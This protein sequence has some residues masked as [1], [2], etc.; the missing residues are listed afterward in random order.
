MHLWGE[1]NERLF[2]AQQASSM[3]PCRQKKKGHFLLSDKVNF[4]QIRANSPAQSAVPVTTFLLDQRRST[5]YFLN[6]QL[7][8]P[9]PPRIAASNEARIT[10]IE[11]TT[12]ETEPANPNAL[13]LVN[14]P[15]KK[16]KACAHAHAHIQ[17]PEP[18]A[19]NTLPKWRQE[20]AKNQNKKPDLKDIG[21]NHTSTRVCSLFCDL[22]IPSYCARGPQVV[23][24]PKL[25]MDK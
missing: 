11:H 9:G 19:Y 8:S 2:H 7:R 22:A 24:H 12:S 21:L 13:T 18:R 15:P 25:R 23:D 17:H 5:F 6:Q 4:F 1:S 14:F 20:W 10:R 16:P 3:I